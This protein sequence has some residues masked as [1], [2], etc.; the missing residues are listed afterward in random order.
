MTDQSK[1][2]PALW[3]QIAQG[4]QTFRDYMGFGGRRREVVADAATLRRFLEQRASHVAQTSLYGY[5]RTRAGQR[6]P[7]LFEEDIFVDALNIAKWQVWL[8]CLAD[9]T[10]YAGG[11][12]AQQQPAAETRVTQLLQE[13]VDTILRDTGIPADSGK[14]FSAHADQIRARITQCRWANVGEG[15]AAFSESPA[16]LYKWAPLV[17]N[18]KQLDEEIVLNSVRFRWQEVRRDLRQALDIDA[19]LRELP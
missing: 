5:L 11:L 8:A 16:A 1:L 6:Y 18:L 2:A 12:L 3:L 10:V 9:V 14:D 13:I 19:V 7:E 4:W 17:D 15:E